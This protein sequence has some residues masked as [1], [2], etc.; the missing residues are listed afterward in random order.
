M[1]SD[2]EADGAVDG[3]V[4]TVSRDGGVVDSRKLVG[5]DTVLAG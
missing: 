4:V 3:E 2:T 5:G 1:A